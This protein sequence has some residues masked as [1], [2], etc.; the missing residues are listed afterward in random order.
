MTLTAANANGLKCQDR[1]GAVP[2]MARSGSKVGGR[3]VGC[4]WCGGAVPLKTRGKERRFCST[5]C[6][7]RWHAACRRIGE[8]VLE[9]HP[10]FVHVL[11]SCGSC[12]D[13][14]ARDRS[15][16]GSRS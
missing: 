11:G 5:G 12:I 4:P 3:A 14:A 15:E 8:L 7:N 6:K 10:D 1:S 9:G 16:G 2:M 13:C